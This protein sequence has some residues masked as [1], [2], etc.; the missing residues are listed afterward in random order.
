M[1]DIALYRYYSD[2]SD[3]IN[4]KDNLIAKLSNEIIKYL[5]S[6]R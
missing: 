6:L 5:I 1:S 2:I 4:I 3:L